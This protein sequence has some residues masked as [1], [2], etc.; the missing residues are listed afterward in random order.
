M[1]I[2]VVIPTFSR[3]AETAA[4]IASA[5]QQTLRP[6]EVIVVDDASPTPFSPAEHG[7]SDPRLKCLRHAENQGAAAARNTGV[8]AA[9]SDWVAFLDSD[10]LWRPQKLA[11]QAEIALR[12]RTIEAIACGFRKSD[13]R[14]ARARDQ[15]PIPS[16]DVRDFAS[17]C[18]HCPGST[19]LVARRALLRIGQ[20]DAALRR[21]ED[22]EWWLRFGLEGG[23]LHVAPV[24]GA[25]IRIGGRPA[26]AKVEESARR[27]A[28]RYGPNAE[29]PLSPDLWRRL[30]AYLALERAA[31]AW[32]VNDAPATALWLARSFA[33]SPR[34]RLHL[35][36]FWRTPVES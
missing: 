19:A 12:D 6:C 28:A 20:F 11:A 32:S 30:S 26:R 4:A 22:L 18:W 35:Q 36:R 2:S 15:I 7:L 8:A 24:I 10:D 29:N 5:L 27:I 9:R 31:A 21:L 33:L 17:G 3:P 23:A 16:A 13:V 34:A 1:D 14:E 25:E